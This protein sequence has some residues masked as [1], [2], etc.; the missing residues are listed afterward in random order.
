[1][2]QLSFTLKYFFLFVVSLC[3]WVGGACVRCFFFVVVLLFFLF[4]YIQIFNYIGS[5]L[6]SK[7]LHSFKLGDSI[8]SHGTTDTNGYK[9]STRDVDNDFAPS[10]CA[11]ERKGAWWHN[12]CTWANLNGIYGNG[13][14]VTKGTCNFWYSL[15]NSLSGVKT[16][17]MMVRRVY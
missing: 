2:C 11:T 3:G 16:S 12:V 17:F 1:M 4:F 9:F 6:P 10:N 15:S 13:S 5:S 8:E 14:C 7:F